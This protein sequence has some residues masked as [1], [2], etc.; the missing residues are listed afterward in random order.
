MREIWKDICGYE[1]MYQ[2]SNLG[3]V[4]SLTRITY[5]KDGKIANR[6]EEKV[7][8]LNSTFGGYLQVSLRKNGTRKN[9]RVH[10]LVAEYFIPNPDNKP[11]VNHKN[12]DVSD[13][14]VDN[15]EWCTPKENMKHLEINFGFDYGRKKVLVYTLDGE[16]VKEF[17]SVSEAGIFVGA[18]MSSRGKVMT[19][20]IN[21]S[22]RSNGKQT[23]YGYRFTYSGNELCTD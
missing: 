12:R 20:N 14:S 2:I 6:L 8:K 16:F 5:N 7:M 3:N 23:A 18:K 4:K 22:L 1:G 9:V 13:N 11:E 21:R 10:R 19:G 17:T 15:L